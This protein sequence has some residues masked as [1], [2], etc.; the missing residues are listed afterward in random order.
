YILPPTMPVS[1]G[2]A[3]F[4]RILGTCDATSAGSRLLN[5][6]L[7]SVARLLTCFDHGQADRA[8]LLEPIAHCGP[9][10]PGIRVEP[11]A[12]Q[13]NCEIQVGPWTVS[14]K[15]EHVAI[16]LILK[17]FIVGSARIV[18]PGRSISYGHRFTS[19]LTSHEYR[20]TRATAI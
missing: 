18:R 13:G 19:P 8:D 7:A 2:D 12:H 4:C 11:S 15:P 20:P 17:A 14:L 10:T 9:S 5:T 16:D 1:S 3:S 6:P